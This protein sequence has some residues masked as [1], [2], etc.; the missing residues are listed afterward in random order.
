[1]RSTRN[2]KRYSKYPCTY[3]HEGGFNKCTSSTLME[4]N[5]EVP[6]VQHIEF[7]VSTSTVWSQLPSNLWSERSIIRM[8]EL[9][10]VVFADEELRNSTTSLYE[11]SPVQCCWSY[12]PEMHV[13]LRSCAIRWQFTRHIYANNAMYHNSDVGIIPNPAW[14]IQ[15]KSRHPERNY[16]FWPLRWYPVRSEHH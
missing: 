9:N 11:S 7:T 10:S 15:F 5:A 6:R 13:L 8:E 3:R 1:M 16:D 12:I 2:R 4:M 14:D